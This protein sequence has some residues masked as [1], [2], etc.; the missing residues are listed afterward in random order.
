MNE[1]FIKLFDVIDEK[2]KNGRTVVAIEGGSASGKTT[3]ARLI[4]EK[5]DC[6]VFHMD[7]FFLRSE[8]RTKERYAEIGGNVDRERFLSEVLVPLINGESI[9]YR[10]F[11]CSTMSLGEE[12]TVEIKDLVII[13]G[14]YCMHPD[15]RSFYDYSV[16]L[17]IT[18]ELQKQRIIKRNSPALAQRF[19]SEWIPMENRYFKEFNIKAKCNQI[20]KITEEE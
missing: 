15:L 10:P 3:L 9:K 5:Y 1:K 14:A 20:I 8:Q 16:F 13:E 11:D 12:I 19:F 18:K 17:D 4:S 7:D 6:T 2:L